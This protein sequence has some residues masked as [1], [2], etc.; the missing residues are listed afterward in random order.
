MTK[1]SSDPTGLTRAHLIAPHALRRRSLQR[2]LLGSRSPLSLAHDA[3]DDQRAIRKHVAVLVN[4]Q[5]VQD[6]RNLERLLGAGE[7]VL[8]VQALTGASWRTSF[9]GTR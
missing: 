3:F 7:R 6:R 5:M 8:L 1:S 4:Q 9:P 2:I